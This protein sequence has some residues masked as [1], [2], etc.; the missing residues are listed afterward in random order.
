MCCSNDICQPTP[1]NPS[2]VE[3]EL[4]ERA[5]LSKGAPLGAGTSVHVSKKLP[6]ATFT[7][8]PATPELC[9]F[10]FFVS[11]G[12]AG[13][14]LPAEIQCASISPCVNAR[15]YNATSA[16]SISVWP[17]SPHGSP[18]EVAQPRNSGY[19]SSSATSSSAL[20]EDDRV[21][22]RTPSIHIDP[23]VPCVTTT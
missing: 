13:R 6:V 20:N 8:S 10:P 17:I 3:R 4:Y 18:V 14:L 11:T 9:D 15:S 21:H 2:R 7:G 1:T 5:R 23:V 22:L 12:A 19:E 16:R